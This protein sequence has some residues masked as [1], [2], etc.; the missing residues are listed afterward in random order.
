VF[1][2]SRHSIFQNSLLYF[3]F[4][5]THERYSGKNNKLNHVFTIAKALNN[6]DYQNWVPFTPAFIPSNPP[7]NVL[8]LLYTEKFPPLF[9]GTLYT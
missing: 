5:D 8:A 4:L 2:W 7:S 3:D 9:G 1:H 6:R